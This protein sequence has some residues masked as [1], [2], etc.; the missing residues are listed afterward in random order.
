[1]IRICL[2]FS[3]LLLAKQHQAQDFDFLVNQL[4]FGVDISNPSPAVIKEFKK[5]KYLTYSDTV[6]MQWNLGA[7]IYEK[8]RNKAKN[9]TATHLFRF[10]QSPVPGTVIQSGKI[11]VTTRG[12]GKNQQFTSMNWVVHFTTK[13]ARETFYNKLKETL[14]PVAT[15]ETFDYEGALVCSNRFSRT[16]KIKTGIQQLEVL[17]SDYYPSGGYS[18]LLNTTTGTGPVK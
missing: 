10:T 17:F 3:L 6:I 5:V 7:S 16:D 12:K 1:M 18:L 15:I 13:E 11:T 8:G 4:Y 14:Q 2:A 9:K